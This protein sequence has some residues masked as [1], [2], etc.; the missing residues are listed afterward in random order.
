MASDRHQLSKL[1]RRVVQ[2]AETALDRQQ[3]VAPVDVLVGIGW[4]TSSTVDRWRQGQVDYL[5]QAVDANLSKISTAM[6][7]FRRWA[8]SRDLRPSE[9]TYVA[10]ARDRRALRFNKS[11]DP[12]LETAFRTHWVSA[13]LSD[14]KRQKMTESQ[15][16]PSDL[17][18]VSALNDWECTE[19]GT[20]G[21]CS[22]WKATGRSAWGVRRWTISCSWPV[23]TRR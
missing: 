9:T 15:S 10:R 5:E 20:P 11:G 18:V 17:V 14:A 19:C 6:A 13:D 4:L 23:A 16:R 21:N 8:A 22:S 7:L 12:N 2:A 1:E 3:Y